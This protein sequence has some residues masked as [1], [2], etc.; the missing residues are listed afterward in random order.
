MARNW[1]MEKFAGGDGT[2]RNPYQ[3][4]N[5]RQLWLVREEYLK[6]F[7]FFELIKEIDL[8]VVTEKE[9]FEPIGDGKN[10]F[11]GSFN[12][13]NK[14]IKNLKIDRPGEDYVG[15]FGYVG[16]DGS[17]LNIGLEDVDVKGGIYVGGLV[18]LGSNGKDIR[19]SHVTGKVGGKSNVGGLVGSNGGNITHSYATANVTVTHTN[20]RSTGGGLVGYNH[21][22]EIFKSYATGDV[23]GKSILGGFVGHNIGNIELSYAT[24]SVTGGLGGGDEYQ[25]GGFVGYNEGGPIKKSYAT[26]N[27]IGK[28]QVGGFAGRK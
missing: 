6:K 26:G 25:I 5:A 15:L 1:A 2:Y 19:N 4:T 11:Q 27:V 14:I 3:I 28:I 17:I 20:E 9:G 22:G 23:K 12:G 24:G 21:G 8:S 13:K 16:K 7:H 10:P 18:G